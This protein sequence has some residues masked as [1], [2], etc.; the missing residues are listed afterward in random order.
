[1]YIPPIYS[2]TLY[3][4]KIYKVYCHRP[5]DDGRACVTLTKSKTNHWR[6]LIY[7]HYRCRLCIR[8]YLKQQYLV[9]Q[10]CIPRSGDNETTIFT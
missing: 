2:P 5:F 8:T 1:M 7:G 4:I 9:L 6:K 3:F 10:Q